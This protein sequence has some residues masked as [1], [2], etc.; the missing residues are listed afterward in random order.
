[1]AHPGAFFHSF[2]KATP[3]AYATSMLNQGREERFQSFPETRNGIGRHLFFFF[4]VKLH[5]DQLGAV[6]TPVIW[7]PEDLD[8]YNLH[9][10]YV[11]LVMVPVN[12]GSFPANRKLTKSSCFAKTKSGWANKK[13]DLLIL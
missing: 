1:M 2:K 7:A 8:F 6:Y 12:P 3:G 13:N 11:V 10:A 9:I 5:L 4:Q